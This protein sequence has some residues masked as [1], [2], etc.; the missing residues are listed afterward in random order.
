MLSVYSLWKNVLNGRYIIKWET[1]WMK[2]LRNENV[3]GSTK[4]ITVSNT[5]PKPHGLHNVC[6]WLEVTMRILRK[7]T[8][9]LKIIW[10]NISYYFNKTWEVREKEKENNILKCSYGPW[11]LIVV[12]PSPTKLLLCIPWHKSACRGREAESAATGSTTVYRKLRQERS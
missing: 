11:K 2:S 5:T 6:S 8:L 10:Q 7:G 12:K 9:C 4:E 1:N 3:Y